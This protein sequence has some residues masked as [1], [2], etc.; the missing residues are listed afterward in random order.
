MDRSWEYIN[1]SQTHECGNWDWGR[2]IPRKGIHKW[3][4]PC[5]VQYKTVGN[6]IFSSLSPSWPTPLHPPPTH[7]LLLDG[8]GKTIP[9][10]PAAWVISPILHP[11]Q[12]LERESRPPPDIY[13]LSRRFSSDSS[14]L[15]R[16]QN[17]NWGRNRKVLLQDSSV[18]K[19]KNAGNLFSDFL[20]FQLYSTV[21]YNRQSIL[22]WITQNTKKLKLKL[23]IKRILVLYIVHTENYRSREILLLESSK[24]K[25]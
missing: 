17:T 16:F 4:F 3:N 12:C 14:E 22:Y 10:F 8:W 13:V 19:Q 5:S 2:A 7:N 24:L 15:N 9:W 21:Q 18:Y 1:G 20:Q 25:L 11:G 6:A 23:H